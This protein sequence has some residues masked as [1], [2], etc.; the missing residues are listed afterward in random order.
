MYNKELLEMNSS[1][2]IIR[3]IQSVRI[4][5]AVHVACMVEN[6]NVSGFWWEKVRERDN[7]EDKGVDGTQNPN[8]SSRNGVECSVYGGE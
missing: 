8:R 3:K 4:R 6:K 7:F 1:S 2:N 5:W